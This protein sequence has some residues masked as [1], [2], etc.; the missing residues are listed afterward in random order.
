[1]TTTQTES[2]LISDVTLQ[3]ERALLGGMMITP[4]QFQHETWQSV[5]AVLREENLFFKQHRLIFKAMQLLVEENIPIDIVTLA[6]RLC[7]NGKILAAGGVEWLKHII[8]DTPSWVNVVSYARTV[9]EL[10]LRRQIA[11]FGVLLTQ[12]ASTPRGDNAAT[13]LALFESKL[14]VLHEHSFDTFSWHKHKLDVANAIK[15]PPPPLQYVVGNLP[16]EP[17]SFGLII[18]PDG[19]RKSWLALHAAVS[20]AAG[21]EVAG[22]LWPARGSGRVVYVTTEDSTNELW[23]RLHTMSVVLSDTLDASS[24]SEN[25]DILP[26]SQT[27]R[28]MTLVS[29]TPNGPV[30]TKDL[31]YLIDFSRGAYL[32]VIDPVADFVD[33]DDSSDRIGRATV[34]ALRRLSRETLAGV[35]AIGHQNKTSMLN[36][37]THQQSLRGSSRVAAGARWVVTLQ[38]LGIDAKK[39]GIDENE[40]P[41]WTLVHEP[42]NSY[43]QTSETKA[44]YHHNEFRLADGT[45]VLGIPMYHSLSAPCKHP[46]KQL[47]TAATKKTTDYDMCPF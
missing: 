35:L 7:R 8:N 11:E 4:L 31:A 1:M 2:V 17:G 40:S 44:L 22:G 39:Y 36:R 34:N 28:G 38:P 20:A 21:L 15:S 10:S 3:A 41:R 33:G 37:D 45:V 14:R 18:G 29:D 46:K 24:L 25:L 27:E 19:S 30:E 12:S 42:K 43:A 9:R 47:H 23:R 6:E 13:L 16:F 32:I 5:T 26:I